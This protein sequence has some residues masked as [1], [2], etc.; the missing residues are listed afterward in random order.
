MSSRV[1]LPVRLF[2]L[3][4]LGGTGW[5]AA[6]ALAGNKT[7]A[8]RP[9]VVARQVRSPATVK[10]VDLLEEE[11][12][13][14][15][16][17]GE[18]LGKEVRGILEN[19]RKQGARDPD[20]ALG[21]VKRALTAVIA[22][23]DVDP[24]VRQQLQARLQAG[25]DE[26]LGV[27]ERIQH[28]RLR[29]LERHSA[30][31][32][33]QLAVDQLVQRD[34]EIE[35][36]IDK[37]RSLM[38][39]GFAGNGG[40]FEEAE[41]VA[42]ASFE[43]APYSGV[44][45]A[46]IFDSEAAGQLDKAQRLRFLRYDK[47]LAQLQEVEK[48]HVPFPDEPP[49]LYPAPEVWKALTERRQKWTS[50]D[51]VRYN[52]TEEKIRGTLSRPTTVDFLDL[53]LED[54]I[55]FLKE[56]HNIN[57]WLDKATLVDEGVVLDQPVTLQLAGATMRSVLKL[58]LEPLQL[59]YV[60]EN[61]VMKITTTAKAGEKL[62]TRVYPVGDLVIPIFTPRQTGL[63]GALGN[64]GGGAGQG[65]GL[66]G[67]GGGAG[68]GLGGAGAGGGGLGGGLGGGFGFFNVPAISPRQ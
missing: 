2:V 45:S 25:I 31:A 28:D 55:T 39:E 19:A 12:A 56:Y 68:G 60:I 67:L 54:C 61:E 46:A 4:F 5:F 10:E 1:A 27:R 15:S 41:A 36:F 59:T 37:V 63:A 17:R 53:P 13:R 51:L 29:S 50:V 32:A 66:G 33:Q 22:A 24:D 62:S 48:S 40:A 30:R 34:E 58:L 47:F 14:R 9:P 65:G 6:V 18:R 23:T 38:T 20:A 21:E 3:P 42:R 8:P 64:G 35:Q 7:E 43:L 16:I 52:P 11:R 44:T 49:I 26:L 57:I